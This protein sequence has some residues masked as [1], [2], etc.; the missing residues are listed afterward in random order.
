MADLT[1]TITET[2]TINGT[3]RG[4][5]NTVTTTG[6][7]DTLE[8]TISCIHSQTTTIAEFGATPHAAASNIDRDNVKYLRVTNLDDTNECMLGVVTGASNYQVRLRAGA[9][10]ILYNG[11]D[12]AIGEVCISAVDG[13]LYIRQTDNTIKPIDASEDDAIALAIALG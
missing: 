6:I 9:S 4:S 2:V 1:T 11:D 8:R 7:V 12:I 13:K 5:T 3:N 10:H